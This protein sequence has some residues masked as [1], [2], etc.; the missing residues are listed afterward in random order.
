[1]EHPNCLLVC[2]LEPCFEE[3]DDAPE[4]HPLQGKIRTHDDV[5]RFLRSIRWDVEVQVRHLISSLKGLGAPEEAVAWLRKYQDL[6][7]SI[8]Q[9]VLP[10][11]CR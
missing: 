6:K 3:D 10:P 5:V 8:W 2:L 1:M 9:L 7:V 11:N 4:P